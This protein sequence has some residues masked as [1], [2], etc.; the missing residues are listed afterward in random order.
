MKLP[1]P[2]QGSRITTAGRGKRQAEFALQRFLHRAAH[3]LHNLRRGV[4]NAV[5][6]RHLHRIAAEE[7]L[8]NV[9]Q[10]NCFSLKSAMVRA[11]ASMAR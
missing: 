2:V 4:D 8:V 10:N 6:V 5:R 9:V 3:V 1:V 11:A 7:T